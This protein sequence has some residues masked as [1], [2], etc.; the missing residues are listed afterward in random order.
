MNLETHIN[1]CRPIKAQAGQERRI[2]M[3]WQ[4]GQKLSPRKRPYQLRN[5]IINLETRLFIIK[6][7]ES[8]QI[9][10]AREASY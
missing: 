1:S 2:S 4:D 3:R 6:L 7:Q 9:K 5:T 8:V 10:S